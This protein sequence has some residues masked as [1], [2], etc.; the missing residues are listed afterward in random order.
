MGNGGN[1]NA[2]KRMTAKEN[3]TQFLTTTSIVEADNSSLLSKYMFYL[4]CLTSLL[5]TIL[6][7]RL[8]PCGLIAYGISA[9]LLPH[10][11]SVKCS[12]TT[13]TKEMFSTMQHYQFGTLYLSV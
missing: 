9:R 2:A 11:P 4:F 3:T 13:K 7:T 8:L 12:N 6:P 10:F 5:I 1:D